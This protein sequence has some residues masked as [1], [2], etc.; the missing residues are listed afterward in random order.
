M[1][2]FYYGT[3][4]AV[5]LLMGVVLRAVFS[6]VMASLLIARLS[7]NWNSFLL[8]LEMEIGEGDYQLKKSW[9]IEAGA[10]GC[11]MGFF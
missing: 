3:L 10:R 7:L 4:L 5:V 2:S 1:S 9:I 6:E 8:G 11:R